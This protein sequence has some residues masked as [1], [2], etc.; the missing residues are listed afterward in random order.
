MRAQASLEFL[1]IAS[2]IAALSLSVISLYGRNISQQ[3][4]LLDTIANSVMQ[5]APP[6][7]PASADDPQAL[8]YVP[9][10]STIGKASSIQIAFYGCA[11]GTASAALNS[12]SIAFVSNRSS[13]TISNIAMLAFPFTP[14]VP[15]TDS[16]RISYTIRCG[17]ETRNVSASFLTYAISSEG[18][19]PESALYSASIANR[20]EKVS[21][22]LDKPPPI[23]NVTEWNQCTWKTIFGNP[24][25]TAT[26]CGPNAW[27]YTVFSPYCY[28]TLGF[29]VTST[30]CIAPIA[31]EYSAIGIEPGAKYMYN[32]TLLLNTPSG[33][34][35]SVLDSRVNTSSIM[36]NNR[37]VGDAHITSVV[38]AVPLPVTTLIS[39]GNSYSQINETAYQQYLQAKSNL[40]D[41]LGY[42]NGVSATYDEESDMQEAVKAF[43]TS[44]RELTSS[45]VPSAACN[46]SDGAYVCNSSYPF[47]YVI[48]ANVSSDGQP[49]NETLSYMGSTID[50][51]SR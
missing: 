16:I 47:A 37:S 20:S 13:S 30:Y 4:G 10:S 21:Y 27:G 36:L 29:S 49:G 41:V 45:G 31:T 40:Y 22:A 34:M 43:I 44:L 12:Q 26:Q 46:V 17:N 5:N 2:A 18:A 33:T 51:S 6:Y 19:S 3:R 35:R 39:N 32:F 7:N 25:S 14:M 11:Y 15:G 42:Y 50:F 9:A 28:Y 38:G 8:I 23:V 48:E 1:L 24:V